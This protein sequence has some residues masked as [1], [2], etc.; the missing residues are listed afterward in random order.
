[1]N[2]TQINNRI[3][4][5]CGWKPVQHWYISIDGGETALMYFD[6][7]EQAF[8]K[9]RLAIPC[10]EHADCGH[11]EVWCEQSPVPN[12]CECLNS[13]YQA[14]ATL[15]EE[16]WIDYIDWMPRTWERAVHSTALVRAEAFLRTFN[17]WGIGK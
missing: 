5:L 2:K 4:K 9:L 14:E 10:E 11:P 1:M 3:A 16:Q 13:M 15:N 17:K 6:T 7:Q 8:E 12:Y